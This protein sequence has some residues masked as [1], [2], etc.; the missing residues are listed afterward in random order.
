VQTGFDIGF[1][2][3]ADTHG[4]SS[5]LC[6]VDWCS[7]GG[8]AGGVNREDIIL[9][10]AEGIQAKTLPELYD[11]YNIRKSFDVPSPTQ[12]VLL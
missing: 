7:D 6:D 3:E 2:D 4:V 5:G 10:I 11:E 9:E 8:G 12:I 1:E